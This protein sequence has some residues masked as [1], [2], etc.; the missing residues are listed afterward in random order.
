MTNIN[1]I[2][3]EAMDKM[4]VSELQKDQMKQ[5]VT[6]KEHGC[7]LLTSQKLRQKSDAQ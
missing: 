1:Q 6:Q 3:L 2:V 5:T 7:Q 4:K